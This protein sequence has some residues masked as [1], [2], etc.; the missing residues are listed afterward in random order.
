[1]KLPILI[2]NIRTKSEAL[3]TPL[4]GGKRLK[5]FWIPIFLRGNQYFD[6]QMAE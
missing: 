2:E 3:V 4:H 1:M 6:W 5:I